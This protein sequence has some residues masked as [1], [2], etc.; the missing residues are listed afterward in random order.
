MLLPTLAHD[1][2]SAWGFFVRGTA[3]ARA[4]GLVPRATAYAVSFG[5]VVSIALIQKWQPSWLAISGNQ[6]R[7]SLGAKLALFGS[8]LV[9]WSLWQLRHSFSVEPQARQLV[10]TGPYR[11][12]RHPIYTSYLLQD[13]GFWL[14]H[15]SLPIALLFLSW[16][17]LLLLRVRYEEAILTS[18]FPEY[19]RYRRE[20]GRF[21][22]KLFQHA[23][24]TRRPGV[25]L[26][27]TP[28]P[29]ETAIDREQGREQHVA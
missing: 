8:L 19:L 25:R 29:A 4:R 22:P 26:E 14:V 24:A 1:L 17:C 9:L 15:P 13:A 12:A 27:V 3:I 2:F 6:V 23:L 7:N 10:T 21:G 11:L 5:P 20:V 18:A 28:P 16:F